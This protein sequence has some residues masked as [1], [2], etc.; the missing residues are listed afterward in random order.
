MTTAIAAAVDAAELAA[1]V[2]A[3][4]AAAVR[5][6]AA[7]GNLAQG[8]SRPPSSPATSGAQGATDGQG[9]G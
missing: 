5:N 9:G 1:A 2:Q 6:A 3:S 8:V 4:A 7:I